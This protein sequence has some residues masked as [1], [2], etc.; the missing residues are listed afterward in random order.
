M[1]VV[2]YMVNRFHTHLSR[3]M[4]KMKRMR[5]IYKNECERERGVNNIQG[6]S[7]VPIFHSTSV[8]S[9]TYEENIY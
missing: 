2:M 1:Y 5:A 7:K 6:V 9:M 8:G 3:G 4:R